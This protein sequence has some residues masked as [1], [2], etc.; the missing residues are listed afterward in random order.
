MFI[1]LDGITDSV[2]V[3][4]MWF[5]GSPVGI[6]FMCIL[7]TMCMYY[8]VYMLPYDR[9]VGCILGDFGGPSGSGLSEGRTGRSAGVL[10]GNRRRLSPV[11]G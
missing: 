3:T 11:V 6:R 2:K 4:S 10:G 9:P 1:Y 5:A 8:V 7:C